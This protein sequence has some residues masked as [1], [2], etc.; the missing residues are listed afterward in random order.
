MAAHKG[1]VIFYDGTYYR[2]IDVRAPI[3]DRATKVITHHRYQGE[4]MVGS[5]EQLEIP[6]SL[7]VKTFEGNGF[8][9]SGLG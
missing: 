9:V 5:V 1:D 4:T 2:I 6:V 8:G 7:N 3:E